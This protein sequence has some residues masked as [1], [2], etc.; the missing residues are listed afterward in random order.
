MNP[1]SLRTPCFVLDADALKAN[2]QGFA[3]ALGKR[4]RALRVAYSVKTNAHPAVLAVLREAGAAAEVVSDTEYR[5]ARALG[6]DDIIFNGPIKGEACFREALQAGSVVN[7]DSKRE[8][9]WLAGMP[10]G[11]SVAVGLRV[12]VSLPED[13][14]FSRFGFDG[15]ELAAAVARIREMP[16]VRLAGIHLHRT[17]KSRSLDVY[18]TLAAKASEVI[19]TFG[20]KPAYID[21]GGGFFGSMPGKPGFDDYA[22]VLAEGLEGCLGEETRLIVE[23]G[24]ALIASPLTMYASVLDTKRIAGERVVVC[25][26]SRN[27]IDPF[28]RKTDYF[29]FFP[30]LEEGRPRENSQTVVGCTCLENDRL[31]HLTDGPRLETG[32]RI[33]FRFTGAYT[34][35]LSPLFI[36]YFPRVYVLEDGA[37]RLAFEEWGARQYLSAYGI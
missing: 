30:A 10:A 8:L 34:M 14:T 2:Y 28:F 13:E 33:G 32:D 18:R 36:R 26:A 20:L 31:F 21:I 11:H 17:S 37:C 12:N 4:F 5:L 19:R 9:D 25:D 3:E 1:E 22:A 6:F 7:I 29:K 16:H 35:A 15:P 23:P 27:D 24:N